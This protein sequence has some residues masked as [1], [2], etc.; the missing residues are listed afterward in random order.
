[1][2]ITKEQWEQVMM[3]LIESKCAF[4]ARCCPYKKCYIQIRHN[5][6]KFYFTDA[7]VRV[8][9]NFIQKGFHGVQV[10]MTYLSFIVYHDPSILQTWNTIEQTVVM[11]I[12]VIKHSRN[13][14]LSLCYCACNKNICRSSQL[15][16]VRTFKN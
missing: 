6:G 2:S 5:Y 12:I 7:F 14:C 4:C 13:A 3:E 9:T 1:M 15:V 11:K 16:V 8:V 10:L